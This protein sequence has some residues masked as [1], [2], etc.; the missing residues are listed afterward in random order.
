MSDNNN[1]WGTNC[2]IWSQYCIEWSECIA[3]VVEIVEGGA[4]NPAEWGDHP[5]DN[6]EDQQKALL[7]FQIKNPVKRGKL[8][9]ILLK[10][11]NKKFNKTIEIPD[12]NIF[13]KINDVKFII[14]TLNE[15]GVEIKNIKK[16]TDDQ[17][18]NLLG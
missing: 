3:E 7:D 15:V 1:L 5:F 11:K 13:V 18:K 8:V 9:D 16:Y 14:K 4:R 17:L 6:Y 2:S 10:C 12:K